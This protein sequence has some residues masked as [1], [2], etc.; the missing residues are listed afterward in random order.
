[1]DHCRDSNGISKLPLI[2]LILPYKISCIRVS[3]E[4][5]LLSL[6]HSMSLEIPL[7]SLDHNMNLF[8]L[9]VSVWILNMDAK[10]SLKL[11][12]G[13]RWPFLRKSLSWNILV[14][15]TIFTDMRYRLLVTY[16]KLYHGPVIN[17]LCYR[18]L[19]INSLKD[20]LDKY[21][22]RLMIFFTWRNWGRLEKT[23]TFHDWNFF[24]LFIANSCKYWGQDSIKRSSF[25]GP[26][27][28]PRSPPRC[29]PGAW[30]PA[31]AD[32]TREC[33]TR[34]SP[35]TRKSVKVDML[36]RRSTYF[37]LCLSQAVS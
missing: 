12:N 4:I 3:F 31:I 24:H 20:L 14:L 25:S 23:T 2:Q 37:R 9:T 34:P 7:L 26:R 22:S 17:N 6:D 1:M 29:T 32:Q 10:H 5:P 21:Q 35:V 16:W 27:S 15:K 18:L 33:L 19:I 36:S 11:D 30:S 8:F 13:G 28:P